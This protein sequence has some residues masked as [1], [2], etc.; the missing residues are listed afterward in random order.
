M[1]S[2]GKP[3][4]LIPGSGIIGTTTAYYERNENPLKLALAYGGC[5]ST[6]VHL[7]EA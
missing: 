7:R 1:C 6:F 3:E 5:K 2:E 4:R